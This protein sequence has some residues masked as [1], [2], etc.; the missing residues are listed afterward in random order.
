MQR[1][2]NQPQ[3]QQ[4]RSFGQTVNQTYERR[5]R[6]NGGNGF[7]GVNSYGQRGRFNDNSS[8]RPYSNYDKSQNHNNNVNNSN[9]SNYRGQTNNFRNNRAFNTGP[10]TEQSLSSLN[11]KFEDKTDHTNDNDYL[12]SNA[13][14]K[15]ILEYIY[16]TIDLSSYKY[17]IL[18]YEYDLPLL[19][20]KPL[21][22]CCNYNGTHSLLVFIK[23]KEKYLSFIID[24]KTLTYNLNQIDYDKVKIIPI[25]VRLDESIYK[26][27]V[28]DGVLLFN[29]TLHQKH[30]VIN[31]IYCF[32]GANLSHDKIH[33]KIMNVAAYLE[34]VSLNKS[35][36]NLELV[37]N[38]SFSLSE[39]KTMVQTYIPNNIHHK[40]IKGLAFYPEYSGMKYLYLFNN[41]MVDSNSKPDDS[42]KFIQSNKSDRLDQSNKSDRLDQSHKSDRNNHVRSDRNYNQQSYD[43][44]NNTKSNDNTNNTNSR[45]HSV[46]SKFITQNIPTESI[47]STIIENNKDYVNKEV[48]F[49]LKKTDTVD[50][51]NLY[52]SQSIAEKKLKLKKIDVACIPTILVSQMWR[53]IFKE[54]TKDCVLAKCK[55]DLAKSKWVP[56]E[57]I[58][59]V[60]FPDFIEV[61]NL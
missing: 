44:D 61:L 23:I 37:I 20:E 9:G 53:N 28:I 38:K 58:D 2:Q 52:L 36:N 41:A 29:Q 3:N 12:S 26:G 22:I 45:V 27:T 40:S 14:K 13:V 48:I 5:D 49:L 42:A 15:V 35:M 50:V 25:Y 47:E 16:N 6:G 17:K 1:D 39:I 60:K 54:R 7:N 31:D 43:K 34:S 55:Y 8:Q 11:N 24:R 59:N 4:Q 10:K 30:F 19:K 51:Y 57:L 21:S 18:E 33:N 32:R 46:Q 56:F